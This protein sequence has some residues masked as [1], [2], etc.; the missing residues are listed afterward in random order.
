[1]RTR[2]EVI[3]VG[4]D[5]LLQLTGAGPYATG[6]RVPPL[7]GPTYRFLCCVA[8]LTDGDT[9]TG[10]RLFGEIASYVMAAAPAAPVYPEKRPIVTSG[11][12]FSDVPLITWTLTFEPL[13]NFVRRAGPFDQTSFLQR[14]TT[15]PALVY[16]T[17]AFPAFPLLP[18]YLGLSAYTPPVMRG[19]KQMQW[20]D[21]RFPEQQNEFFAVRRPMTGPTRARLY[22]D[23]AQTDPA[24]RVAPDFRTL[25]S[26]AQL[27]FVGGGMVPEEQFL[28]DFPDA[29]MHSVGGALVFDRSLR[30]PGDAPHER[31]QA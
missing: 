5:D 30:L 1:M 25:L 3:S 22:A 7:V 10:L 27:F 8:D 26:A 19:V 31:A 21:I 15:G 4:F 9:L 12:K 29:V 16:E 17:A 18:G 24:H 11:W 14:D 20:K 2:E 6:L 23:C 13:A 28:Q